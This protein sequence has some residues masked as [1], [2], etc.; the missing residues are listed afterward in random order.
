MRRI[1]WHLVRLLHH[2]GGALIVDSTRHGKKIP[3]SF[4]KTIPIWCSVL[5]HVTKLISQRQTVHEAQLTDESMSLGTSFSELYTPPSA[6]SSNES[7]QICERIPNFAKRFIEVFPELAMELPSLIKKPL[8]PIWLSTSSRMFHLERNIAE[9]LYTGPPT[10]APPTPLSD[11]DFIPV[12]CVTASRSVPDGLERTQSYVY[13]QGSGDDHELWGLGLSPALFWKHKEVLL[14][15]PNVIE[16]VKTVTKLVKERSLAD[17]DSESEDH[18]LQQT[19]DDSHSCQ[20]TSNHSDFSWIKHFGL[21][22]GRRQSGKPPDCWGRFDAI[23]N[24]GAPEY[25]DNC[26]GENSLT[27][28]YLFLPIPEGKRGSSQLAAEIPNVLAF[29]HKK[30]S[31]RK[32]ILIHCAQGKDRSV[33]IAL[34]ILTKYLSD[35]GTIETDKNVIGSLTSQSIKERVL[36]TLGMIYKYHPSASPSQSTVKAV[37]HYFSRYNG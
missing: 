20:E 7:I 36:R 37:R 27:E 17:Y 25:L 1:N 23:I 15:S 21:A 16:C 8:R 19:F 26:T 10:T 2:H 5:N 34:A 3:D 14:N 32:R 29:V 28:K 13:V 35:N 12:I 33:G 4:S 11:I 22:I 6:V 30:L 24:C 18:F 9:W 31:Q